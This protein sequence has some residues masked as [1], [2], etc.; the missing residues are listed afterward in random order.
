MGRRPMATKLRVGMSPEALF[1]ISASFLI[2][3]ILSI[4][5]LPGFW[6]KANVMVPAVTI[7]LS[8]GLPVVGYFFLVRTRRVG[9]WVLLP[10]LLFGPLLVQEWIPDS[11]RDLPK[12]FELAAV[13][14]EAGL[15]LV[16]ALS[17]RRIR[18][19]YRVE[20]YRQPYS[21][22]AVRIALVRVM[23]RRVGGAICSELA[24]LWY[25]LAGWRRRSSDRPAG[26]VFPGYHRNAY[27]ALL[28]AVLL[29]GLIETSALH[30]LVSLWRGSVAWVLTGLGAY[31]M[32]WLLGDFHAARHNPSLLTESHLHL[33]TGLRWSADIALVDIVGVHAAEPEGKSVR[34]TMFGAPDFWIE[35]AEPTVVAGFFGIQ[36]RVRFLGVG[37]DDVDALRKAIEGRCATSQHVEKEFR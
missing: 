5:A 31:S 36:R 11:R 29:V 8:I 35:S 16:L 13:L 27:P 22:D 37:V 12:T 26:D 3:A 9:S 15:L 14:L 34:M 28:G 33:R 20:Q 19:I 4:V 21:L 1:V 7:D 25:V 2:T 17:V 23:G 6:E 32:V 24:A 10:L 30:L 18:R